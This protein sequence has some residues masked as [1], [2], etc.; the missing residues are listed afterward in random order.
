M[1]TNLL[2]S[3]EKTT[4]QIENS[5]SKR[6]N[7]AS[8]LYILVIGIIIGVFTNIFADGIAESFQLSKVGLSVISFII[9]CLVVALFYWHI[10]SLMKEINKLKVDRKMSMQNEF[11]QLQDMRQIVSATDKQ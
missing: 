4:E 2:N 9:L 8:E 3:Y 10:H 6:V 1:N 7:F 11:N 5:I